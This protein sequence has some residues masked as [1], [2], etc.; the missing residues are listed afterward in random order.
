MNI[1]CEWNSDS[2]DGRM[3]VKSG[4]IVIGNVKD[5]GSEPVLTFAYDS[6]PSLTFSEIEHIMDN[7]YNMPKN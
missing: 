4:N 3:N 5:D 7:W 6:N 1:Y 2:T